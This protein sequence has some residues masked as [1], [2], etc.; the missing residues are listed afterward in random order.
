MDTSCDTGHL[1][2][3]HKGH[4]LMYTFV[5]H[6]CRLVDPHSLSWEETIIIAL[7][8]VSVLAVVAVAAF[9]GYR[10]INGELPLRHSAR[11]GREYS[12][13]KDA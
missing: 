10:M 2:S 13:F 8:T 5:F 4:S 12:L 11:K 6:V 9:F 7:A 3:L 1:L